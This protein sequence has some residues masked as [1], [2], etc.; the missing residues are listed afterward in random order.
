MDRGNRPHDVE[1]V[2]L[3]AAGDQRVQ[4]VL[5]REG[6]GDVGPATGERRNAPV[7]GI[8]GV[9]CLPGLMGAVEIA[10]AKVNQSD[11]RRWEIDQE[12]AEPR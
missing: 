8:R 12:T 9:G 2:A 6:L 4:P 11:R 3:G 5:R 10:Q 1:G 7:G